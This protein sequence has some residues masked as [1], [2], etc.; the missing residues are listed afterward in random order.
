VGVTDRTVLVTGA[1]SGIGRATAEELARR[2]CRV[3]VHGRDEARTRQAAE[4]ISA[5]FAVPAEPALADFARLADVRAPA[6][7]VRDRFDR[8]DVLVN[9]AGVYMRRHV[10]TEDGFETT[11]QVNVLAGFLLTELLLPMLEDSAPSRIVTVSSTT[12]HS[13]GSVDLEELGHPRFYNGYEAYAESKLGDIL[14]TYELAERL[15]PFRVTANCLHPGGVSTKLLH[16][17]FHPGGK[18]PSE[19]ARTP[20]YLALSPEVA[21]VTGRYFVNER[22]ER[23]SAVTYDHD[24]SSAYW[25]A[26]ERMTAPLLAPLR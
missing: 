19:G 10:T 12:H 21:G 23:S 2:G 20:V 26:C 18:P 16:T 5:A 17:G 25:Q 7:G 24:L 6:A 22:P 11:F 13:V 1:T 8:L 14:V 3:I 15:D 4:E 9:N